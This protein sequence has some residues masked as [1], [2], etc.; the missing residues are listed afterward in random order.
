MK[1]ARTSCFDDAHISKLFSEKIRSF[2]IFSVPL[3]LILR[4]TAM[5]ILWELLL[6]LM[7]SDTSRPSLTST[8]MQYEMVVLFYM[9]IS[10]LS[11][12]GCEAT[13]RSSYEP[14]PYSTSYQKYPLQQPYNIRTP[15]QAH[16]HRTVSSNH[17]VGQPVSQVLNASS[18]M[19]VCY[20]PS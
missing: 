12:P 20:P 14:F 7:V 16:S 10:F 6:F 5:F 9:N 13:R 4:A 3:L 15:P 17:I 1:R 19:Y 18:H 2:I 11:I 8:L